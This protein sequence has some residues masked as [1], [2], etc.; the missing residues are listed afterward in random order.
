V[1]KTVEQQR[2]QTT[3]LSVV[4]ALVHLRTVVGAL[5]GQATLM[6][7]PDDRE[8]IQKGLDESGSRIERAITNIEKLYSDDGNE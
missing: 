6:L 8:L 1:S 4:G 7:S 3:L 2:I 5:S